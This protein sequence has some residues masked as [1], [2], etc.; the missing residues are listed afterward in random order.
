MGNNECQ[1]CLSSE[2]E[3][4][5]EIILG[6]EFAN[7]QYI[8]HSRREIKKISEEIPH[9]H[10]S[11]NNKNLLPTKNKNQLNQKSQK[12]INQNNSTDKDNNSINIP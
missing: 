3:M 5:A 8:H 10:I 9:E 1:K 11:N 2:K 6:R 7:K 4:F 12:I